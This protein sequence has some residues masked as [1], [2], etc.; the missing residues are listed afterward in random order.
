MSRTATPGFIA[1]LSA[2]EAT[3]S[4]LLT[5]SL[6]NVDLPEDFGPQIITMRGFASEGVVEHF[7]SISFHSGGDVRGC[8]NAL[9]G[10]S[11]DEKSY[12]HCQHG[13]MIVL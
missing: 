6:A 7:A 3:D 8:R 1:V 12:D 9:Y 4:S 11:L 5:S 13:M 10:P 2:S